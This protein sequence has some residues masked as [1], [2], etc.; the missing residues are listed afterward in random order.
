M[1]YGLRNDEVKY[2]TQWPLSKRVKFMTSHKHNM[3]PITFKNLFFS[4][5]KHIV[6]KQ[7]T[8]QHIC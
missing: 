7:K 4:V 3:I 8:Q 1:K 2:N 5:I 6:L